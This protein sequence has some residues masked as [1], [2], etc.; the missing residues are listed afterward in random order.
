MGPIHPCASNNASR[1]APLGGY[2]DWREILLPRSAGFIVLVALTVLVGLAIIAR[3]KVE[4]AI[5]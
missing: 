5:S 4:T 3:N 1:A 2:E